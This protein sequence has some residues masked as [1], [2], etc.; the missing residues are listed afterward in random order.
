MKHTEADYDE[1]DN[2]FELFVDGEYNQDWRLV[3][4]EYD[5]VLF[6]DTQEA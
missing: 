1:Q 3:E 5:D 2:W 6:D 4:T